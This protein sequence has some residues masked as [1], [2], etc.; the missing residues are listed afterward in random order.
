[1]QGMVL[2]RGQPQLEVMLVTR[3]AAGSGA[4]S[5]HFNGTES[6]AVVAFRGF[7]C[8]EGRL[9]LPVRG[10]ATEWAGVGRHLEATRRMKEGK[11]TVLTFLGNQ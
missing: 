10:P 8:K 9:Q 5:L 3:G 2:G 7:E 1:M 6:A 11:L 4:G